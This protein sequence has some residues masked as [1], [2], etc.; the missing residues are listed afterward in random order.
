[1][2]FSMKMFLQSRKLFTYSLFF[3]LICSVVA[4]KCDKLITNDDT[5]TADHV[6][7]EGIFHIKT[8]LQPRSGEI[9]ELLNSLKDIGDVKLRRQSF[10]ATLKPKHIKKV[11]SISSHLSYSKLTI[12]IPVVV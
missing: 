6:F 11:R 5:A 7:N 9:R 4:L 12:V 3:V 2:Y 1:M 8:T 10:T